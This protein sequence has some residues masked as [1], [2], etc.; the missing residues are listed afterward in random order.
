MAEGNVAIPDEHAELLRGVHDASYAGT[1][2]QTMMGTLKAERPQA[3]A[4]NPERHSVSNPEV[5]GQAGRQ[6][7]ELRHMPKVSRGRL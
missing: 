1:D 6:R 2:A 7:F 4:R 5:R 3:A